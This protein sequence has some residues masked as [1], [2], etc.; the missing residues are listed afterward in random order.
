[1]RVEFVFARFARGSRS[2]L[3]GS[4]R[5]VMESFVLVCLLLLWWCFSCRKA[6]KAGE[7]VGVF[8]TFA[9]QFRKGGLKQIFAFSTGACIV[10]ALP[11]IHLA[12]LLSAFLSSCLQACKE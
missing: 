11:P 3:E 2:L 4:S 10:H 8:E 1:M 9:L 5:T 6:C 7:N 12:C